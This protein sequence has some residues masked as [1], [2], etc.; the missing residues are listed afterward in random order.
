LKIGWSNEFMMSLYSVISFLIPG[1]DQLW[2]IKH[3]PVVC[4]T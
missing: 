4:I 2:V 3:L 1:Q